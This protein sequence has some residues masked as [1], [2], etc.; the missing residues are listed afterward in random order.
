MDRFKKNY[1]LDGW[2]IEDTFSKS[3]LH[4]DDL[5]LVLNSYEQTVTTFEKHTKLLEEQAVDLKS[6]I[7][8]LKACLRTCE[9]SAQGGLDQ[10]NER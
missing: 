9:N 1:T 7:I 3:V 8:D 2:P 4:T 5:T 10:Y 6:T